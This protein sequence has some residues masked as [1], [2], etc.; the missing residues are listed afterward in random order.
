PSLTSETTFVVAVNEVPQPPSI[1]PIDEQIVEI[2]GSTR[3][4]LDVKASDPDLPASS[5]TYSLES[6]PID[7]ATIDASSGRFELRPGD[8]EAGVC[9]ITVKVAK[10]GAS[11]LHAT[12]TFDLRIVEPSG[13]RQMI[14]Q[15]ARSFRDAGLTVSIRDREP[16]S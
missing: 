2:D 9:P 14:R 7:G 13:A 8:A 4:V 1:E 12:Q 16:V 15:L 10:T 6:A 3:F 5:L 11:G